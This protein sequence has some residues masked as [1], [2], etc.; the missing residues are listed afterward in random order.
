MSKLL[1]LI[2]SFTLAALA[3]IAP[4]SHVGRVEATML[5][6]QQLVGSLSVV[7]PAVGPHGGT[8]K[9]A[10][11]LKGAA[12]CQLSLASH[13][14]FP[15]VYSHGAQACAD[16]FS[17]EVTIGANPSKVDRVVTLRLLVKAGPEQEVAP[18]E[19]G[20]LDGE[21]TPF[22]EQVQSRNW[23]GYAV[24]GGPFRGASG[25]FT[26]PS[27]EPT[28]CRQ[29]LGEWVGVDGFGNGD[30]I[31]AGVSEVP[32]GAASGCAGSSLF[33]VWWEVLPSAQQITSMKVRPG[34]VVT[35]NLRQAGPNQW[36]IAITNDTT[37]ARFLH[38]QP[39]NGPASSAEWIV[40]SPSNAGGEVASMI[41]YDQV[42]F[43][44]LRVDDSRF[45]TVVSQ[46]VLM[47]DQ[48]VSVPKA[49]PSLSRLLNG[50]FDV[51]YTG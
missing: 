21:R 2:S 24:E 9:I 26:V 6:E 8:V 7:P 47:Q 15:V 31:Q 27:P 1:S 42:N 22:R 44:N 37:G 38:F 5:P 10:A 48:L 3:G 41:P 20:V 18:V 50:G 23:S 49:A 40:E 14:S 39:Y 11:Q 34:D 35:V 51:F 45:V 43:T 46:V 25:T 32:A 29:A 33:Q 19:I 28:S 36:E 12:S 13:Q 30:L 16:D 4:V 17:G